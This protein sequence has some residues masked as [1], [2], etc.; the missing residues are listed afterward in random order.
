MRLAFSRPTA[1]DDEQ[2]ELLARYV[3]PRLQGSLAGIERSQRWAAEN[4]DTFFAQSATALGSA[5]AAP[6]AGAPRA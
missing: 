5:M 2:R 4:R 1:T 3:V 6:A